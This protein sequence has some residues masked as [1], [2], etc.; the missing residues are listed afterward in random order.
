MSGEEKKEE[1][2]PSV[3][4][5]LEDATAMESPGTAADACIS[6]Q[7]KKQQQQQDDGTTNTIQ[8][9]IPSPPPSALPPPPAASPKRSSGG[10]RLRRRL[11]AAL[12]IC[13]IDVPLLALFGAFVAFALLHHLHDEY[14]HPQ[15]KLMEFQEAGRDYTEVTYYHRRCDPSDVSARTVDELVIPSHYSARDASEHM[16]RHGASVYPNLLTNDTAFELREWIVKENLVQEGWFVLKNKHR[17]SW[18]IDMNMHPKLVTFFR[19][20]LVHPQLVDA[21]QEI[22]GSDPA[23]V[24]FTAITSSY[25]AK[26]Q[27]DHAD[28][29]QGGSATKF[30]HS[31]L[32]TYSLF[33][34]LQDTTYEMGATHVCPGTHVCSVGS[35]DFCPDGNNV[36]L[37]GP[38]GE[39]GIWPMGWGES[40]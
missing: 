15:I 31:F 12:R 36:A 39:G 22:A 38:E 29:V 1:C 2:E 34:P 23:V 10:G 3:V 20:L 6:Q 35:D 25:G 19:E 40:E 5:T 7:Q 37:S 33:V 16:L 18:G 17:Y 28:V 30:A 4:S 13:L 11:G 9:S 26:D 14:F 27:H 24:E 8:T 21:L 32:P